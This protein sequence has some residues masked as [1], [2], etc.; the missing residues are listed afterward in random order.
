MTLP[1]GIPNAKPLVHVDETLPF[2]RY[3][4][5]VTSKRP[6]GEYHSLITRVGS[7]TSMVGLAQAFRDHWDAIPDG[8]YVTHS[9]CHESELIPDEKDG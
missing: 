1:P 9:I 5:S 3:I 6:N 2:K 8:E 7:T 4:I